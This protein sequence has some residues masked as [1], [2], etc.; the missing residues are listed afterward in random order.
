W[1]SSSSRSAWPPLRRD[2]PRPVH[3]L[4]LLAEVILVDVVAADAGERALGEHRQELPSE[5]QGVLDRAVG[6]ALRD[7]VLLERI[8]EAEVEAVVLGQGLFADDR[9]EASEI[10]PLRIGR[11]ELVGHLPVVLP[12]AA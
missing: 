11:V 6:R 4:H 1:W 7:E 2:L 9:D 3:P 8:R 5:G 10:Q 12:R